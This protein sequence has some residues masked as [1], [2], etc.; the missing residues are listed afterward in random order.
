M[1][2]THRRCTAPTGRHHHGDEGK[3]EAMASNYSTHSHPPLA[4]LHERRPPKK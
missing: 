4:P 2:E 1:L 3:E